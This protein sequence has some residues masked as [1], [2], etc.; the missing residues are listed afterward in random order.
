MMLPV[1]VLAVGAVVVGFLD[2]PGLISAFAN[3]INSA[4]EPLVEPTTAQDYETSLVAVAIGI[5]GGLVAWLAFKKGR[6]IVTSRELWTVFS[7]KFYFD[8]V[9]DA[10]FSRPAQL[11][12]TSLRERIEEPIVQGSLGEIGSG[13]EDVAGETARL[14]TGLLR[15]YAL[16][17]AASV[18]VLIVVFVA[19][20]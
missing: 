1:A 2:V 14:Q 3:W 17:V 11:V 13:V 4:A 20:R 7:K 18:A 16:V 9:Y 6:E 15:S 12:A 19:V 10:L 5:L 8:E